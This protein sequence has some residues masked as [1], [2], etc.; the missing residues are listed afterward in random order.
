M[1]EK[2]IFHICKRQ[3]WIEAQKNDKYSAESLSA[4]GFIHCSEK[5]QVAGVLEMFFKDVP[6][7]IL[8]HIDT[9][10]LINEVK[11]EAADGQ[12]FPHIYGELNLDAVV[13]VSEV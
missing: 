3:D 7:L 4:V 8:L 12:V 1:T 9:S 11:Y 5:H 2:H 10:K 13:N 6:D